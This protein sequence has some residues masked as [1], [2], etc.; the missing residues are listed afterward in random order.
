MGITAPDV[1]TTN[2]TNSN[3]TRTI[4]LPT[5]VGGDWVGVLIAQSND[6]GV[7]WTPPADWTEV[8]DVNDDSPGYGFYFAWRR[9]PKGGLGSTIDFIAAVSCGCRA[10]AVAYRGTRASEPIEA[11]S[12]AIVNG[13][14]TAPESPAITTETP[15]A[16]VARLIGHDDN[17]SLTVPSGTTERG[18]VGAPAPT[19]GSTAGWADAIQAVAGDAGVAAWDIADDEESVTLTFALAEGPTIASDEQW[20]LWTTTQMRTD[21]APGASGW[22]RLIEES[23]ME[24]IIEDAQVAVGTPEAQK[25]KVRNLLVGRLQNEVNPPATTLP[26]LESRLNAGQMNSSLIAIESFLLSSTELDP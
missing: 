25:I 12:S 8:V 24:E 19:N 23:S 3:T 6:P 9:A 17:D 10:I 5:H 4:N 22:N 16:L 18:N 7:S 11:V 15:N 13:A 2:L 21:I 26:E 20:A 1:A 14:A